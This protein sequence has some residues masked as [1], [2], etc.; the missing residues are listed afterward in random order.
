[1]A[2]DELW[3]IDELSALVAEALVVD[4]PGP[5]NGRARVVPDQRTIRWYTTIGLL[6]RPTAMRG[7]T[8]LYDRRHLLQLVAIKRLQADGHTLADVQ[9]QL[10]GAPDSTLTHIARLPA[11]SQPAV[12]QPAESAPNGQVTRP[13]P[14]ARFWAARPAPPSSALVHGVRL[15]DGVTVMLAAARVPTQDDLA[16]IADAAGPLLDVLRQ[17]GLNPEGNA[18]D[19]AR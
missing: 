10:V 6:D 18:H 12:S 17:R 7:R 16:A 1:M 13:E 2:P 11:V 8:A 19:N 3:T 4:Y 5:P 9:Q 15:A 14:R